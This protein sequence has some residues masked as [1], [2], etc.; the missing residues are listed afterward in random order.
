MYG[1]LMS[2]PDHAMRTYFEALSDISTE[3]LDEFDAKMSEGTLNPRDVKRRM[4]RE[5]VAE[6]HTLDEAHEAEE[7]FIRQFSERKLPTDIP[8]FALSTPINIVELMVQAGLAASNNKARELI[9]QGGVSLF[10]K[11]ESGEATRITDVEYTVPAEPG[12]ILKVGKR[13]YIRLQA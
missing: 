12:A 9:K 6:F 3:E 10:L 7:A 13:Q 4:A 11:G 5:I 2:L 8:S 1:K